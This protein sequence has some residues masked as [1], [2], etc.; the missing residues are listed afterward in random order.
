MAQAGG[1]V[2]TLGGANTYSGATLISA[3]TLL[4]GASS[5]ASPSSTYIINSAN[6]LVFGSGVTAGTI[7]GLS[8]KR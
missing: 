2:L 5:A 8:W 6:G 7:G 4:L 1:G 3:G